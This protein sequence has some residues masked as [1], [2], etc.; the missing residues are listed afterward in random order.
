M[1]GDFFP[2]GAI[3]CEEQDEWNFWRE[4]SF[5]LHLIKRAIV[6][7]IDIA[8]C[9]SEWKNIQYKL[10]EKRLVRRPKMTKLR[11]LT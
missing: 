4:T 1:R 2:H 3:H 11:F 8:D 7:E 6:P 10:R 9:L 5:A